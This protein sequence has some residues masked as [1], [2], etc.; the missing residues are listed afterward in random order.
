MLNRKHYSL[1]QQLKNLSVGRESLK[2]NFKKMGGAA[3]FALALCNSLQGNA[4]EVKFQHEAT[5]TT[6][7]TTLLINECD[8]ADRGNVERIARTFIGTPYAAGTLDRDSVETLTVN[9][10]SLDCTTFVDNVL[11]LA[12]T[13][14]ERRA[15]WQDFVYNL[16]RLRYRQGEVNGY[17]SRLHY[18]SDWIVDNVSRGNLKEVTAEHPE[19]RYSVKSLDYMTSHRNLYPALANDANY[20]AMR[21]VESGFSN[22]RYP[23]MKGSWTTEKKLA[24]F[25]HSGDIICFTTAT[26]GLDVTHLAIAAVENGVV[27][28]IHCS[29]AAGKVVVDPLTL[30]EY[31]RRNRVE[32]I[33][34]VR[35]RND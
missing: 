24:A 26:K 23:Y 20:A 10:D 14:N 12:Y 27:R 28:I 21:N 29:S 22:H 35:L 2:K 6:R 32:G 30:A 8:N 17:A 1:M 5:D 18:I 15:S 4:Q 19:V 7:I 34:V 13:A 31:I 25:I 33:R 3:I 16:R 11:A 9:L